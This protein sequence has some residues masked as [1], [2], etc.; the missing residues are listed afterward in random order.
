MNS[1]GVDPFLGGYDLAALDFPFL[2]GCND[3]L[4]GTILQRPVGS[5]VPQ[6]TVPLHLN[7][8]VYN[9]T[10]DKKMVVP[11][12]NVTTQ[13]I[14]SDQSIGVIKGEDGTT[15]YNPRDLINRVAE[16]QS[17]LPM[18]NLP[19]P[20]IPNIPMQQQPV[21]PEERI[22]EREIESFDDNSAEPCFHIEESTRPKNKPYAE[23]DKILFT[24]PN[25]AVKIRVKGAHI[26]QTVKMSMRYT[27]KTHYQQPVLACLAHHEPDGENP[28]AT[29]Y[30]SQKTP[31]EYEL[32]NRH[33][34]ALIPLTVEED[35]CFYPIFRCWNFCGK[36]F[37]KNQEMVLTLMMGTEVLHQATFDVRVCENVG[38]DL[39][40]YREERD[41]KRRKKTAV[42]RPRHL[43]ETEAQTS[44]SL[45]E[46]GAPAPKAQYFL[47]KLKDLELLPGL[48]E[49]VRVRGGDMIPF[50]DPDFHPEKCFS[51]T[52]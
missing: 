25:N 20:S 30:V 46:L 52:C 11:G 15:Q 36:K 40:Q 2:D 1:N 48:K 31:I 22:I 12:E 17:A 5:H 47:V 45:Q 18:W 14:L 50:A 29:F 32:E 6:D 28:D 10:N 44:D 21:K 23:E 24:K 39:R 8:L 37:G 27:T 38:R 42:K 34:T 33:P 43:M 35:F 41:G 19:N 4:G 26:G 3:D 9:E 51:N 13:W 16:E 49:L 7:E